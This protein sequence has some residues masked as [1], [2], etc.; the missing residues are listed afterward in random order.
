M[1]PWELKMIKM[2]PSG[3]HRASRG[4]Q[5]KPKL[6]KLLPREAPMSSRGAQDGSREAQ[7]AQMEPKGSPKGA[8]WEPKT[9]KGDPSGC[10]RGNQN[11]IDWISKSLK[12]QWF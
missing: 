6:T 3:S 12:N 2:E 11:D 4:F 10:P 1:E 9:P 5:G 8:Q 7:G